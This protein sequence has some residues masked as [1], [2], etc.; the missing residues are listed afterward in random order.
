MAT[1]MA[2]TIHQ[3]NGF[4]ASPKRIYDIL[5]SSREHAAMTANGVAK[6]SRKA[7]GEF[8]CH[9]GWISG[10]NIE[11]EPGKRIVQAWRARNWP[12]GI[13]SLVTF[14]LERKDR[15][16]R[17]TLDHTGIPGRH[18]DHLTSGWK[19]RY[20]KPLRAYLARHG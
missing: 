11:L 6:I 1:A 5:M 7:G 10:R 20:W 19:A 16:T 18:S 12:P 8:F 2:T 9:G 14:T 17:L 3:I 13:Y 4:K 15:G